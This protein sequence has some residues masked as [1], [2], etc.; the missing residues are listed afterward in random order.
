MKTTA[1]R[2]F[3]TLTAAALFLAAGML[4][5]CAETEKVDNYAVQRR[6]VD[7]L[8]QVTATSSEEAQVKVLA[9][10]YSTH[11]IALAGDSGETHIF[12]VDGDVRN[13]HQIKQGDSVKV[14]YEEVLNV[15]VRKIGAPLTTTELV[16]LERAPAGTK[17]G[18]VAVRTVE[19]LASVQAIDHLARTAVLK[20]PSG[21][22]AHVSVSPKL[23][24]FDK[25]QAGDQVIFDYTEALSITVSSSDQ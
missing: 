25:V 1:G 7:G 8:P 3:A 13:L 19:T 12:H 10:D 14:K 18:L 24:E 16:S 11:A 22:I 4:S 6:S 9:V 5:G 20:M 23:P 15:S 21:T 2:W 17:P